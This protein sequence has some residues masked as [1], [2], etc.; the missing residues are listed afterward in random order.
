MYWV[1]TVEFWFEQIREDD[2]IGQN[3]SDLEAAALDK[4]Q[5]MSVTIIRPF[6]EAVRLSSPGESPEPPTSFHEF[7][8]F[9]HYLTFS[10]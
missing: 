5:G 3:H 2:P 10:I 8:H 4:T 9:L 6:Q 1:I 7:A